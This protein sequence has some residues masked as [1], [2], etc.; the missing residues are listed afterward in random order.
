[1]WSAG[2][3]SVSV[4]LQAPNQGLAGRG[5]VRG[6]GDLDD[7]EFDDVDVRALVLVVLFVDG[8]SADVAANWQRSEVNGVSADDSQGG[9]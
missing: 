4:R 2:V 9:P 6:K 5:E 7:R 8:E 1:M 3:T